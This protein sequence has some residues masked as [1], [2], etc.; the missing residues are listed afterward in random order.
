MANIVHPLST[1]LASLTRQELVQQIRYPKAENEILRS[2]VP[3]RDTLDNRER[4]TFVRHGVKLGRKTKDVM[5][6]VSY[7]TFRR[8]VRK[9]EGETP[10]SKEKSAKRGAGPPKI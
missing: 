1:L 6:I 4:N 10:V 5:T 2:K 8:W 3:S 9:M 7:S